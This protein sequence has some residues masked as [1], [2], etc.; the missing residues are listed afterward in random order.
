MIG[1]TQLGASLLTDYPGGL[2]KIIDF[3]T[4]G[5]IDAGLIGALASMP[6]LMGFSDD[7][8]ASFFRFR[9]VGM[10][11]VTGLTDFKATPHDRRQLGS[12]DREVAAARSS[13]NWL[14]ETR[15]AAWLGSLSTS[16]K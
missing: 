13:E 16:E 8:P 1:S 3:Q 6:N 14:N 4:N 5:K 7:K 9:S 11:A 12:R 2:W 10:A 15:F